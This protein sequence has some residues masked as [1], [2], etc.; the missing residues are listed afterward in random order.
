[1]EVQCLWI[2]FYSSSGV[3]NNSVMPNVCVLTKLDVYSWYVLRNDYLQH[4]FCDD[5]NLMCDM[6]IFATFCVRWSK[7]DGWHLYVFVFSTFFVC[8]DQNLLCIHDCRNVCG[9]SSICMPVYFQ[10]LCMTF[11]YA[12]CNVCEFHLPMLTISM[13]LYLM[14]LQHF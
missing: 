6:C 1:M 9:F 5:S 7:F 3:I 12:I 10:W 11:W 2:F 4:A 13:C 14:H 8:G